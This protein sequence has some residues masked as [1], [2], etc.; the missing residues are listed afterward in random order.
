MSISPAVSIITA[1]YN[2]AAYLPDAVASVMAQTLDDFEWLIADDASS[3]DSLAVIAAATNG[4]PRVRILPGVRNTGPAGARNRALGAAR[5]RWL[6]I[7]DGDDR[8]DPDR[9]K[10]LVAR[11]ETDAAD[12]VVDNLRVFESAARDKA[13]L[14]LRGPSW[15]DPRGISLAQYI[16]SGRMYS[17]KPGLGYLKPLFRATTLGQF[18]YREDLKI[19]EDYDLVLRLLA[20]GATM[21][22]EPAGLYHYRRHGGSISAVLRGTHIEQMLRADA[23][24]ALESPTRGHSEPV[25]A[26]VARRRRSLEVALTYDRVITALKSRDLGPA[27]RESLSQPRVLPLLTMPVAARLRRLAERVQATVA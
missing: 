13:S 19:G 27:I 24:L 20:T 12:I 7:F 3:D 14:F 21:R 25:R 26:A 11:G 4:D 18:R 23:A 2:G 10:I 22:F 15:R 17:R 9:L 1:N 5:G 16:D 6:A 8:M